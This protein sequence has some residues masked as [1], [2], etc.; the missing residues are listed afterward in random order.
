MELFGYPSKKAFFEE[1]RRILHNSPVGRLSPDDE[2]AILKALSLHPHVDEKVGV[3]V[4]YLSIYY[5]PELKARRF[6]IHRIDR[7]QVSFSYKTCQ[8]P[9]LAN[10]HWQR[11]VEACRWVVSPQVAAFKQSRTTQYGFWSESESVWLSSEQVHIDHVCP[12]D[13]L[14]KEWLVSRCLDWNQITI[15]DV[16]PGVR[17]FFDEG[18]EKD[19][20]DY[21][22]QNAKLQVLSKEAN[23]AKSNHL[24][25]GSDR[26]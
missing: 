20:Y 2:Q 25:Q 3:G 8:T 13:R 1:V 7:T 4:A 18:I 12:F 26:P 22:L 15:I 5:A 19:W 14:L 17:Q 10:N 24:T 11:F 21:H 9:S 16:S 6:V 23:I